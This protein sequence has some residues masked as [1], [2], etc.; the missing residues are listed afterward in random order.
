MIPNT[1]KTSLLV[2]YQLPQFV[3]ENPEY[4]NFQVFL[5][6]Y[7]EWL[8]L[9]NTANSAITEAASTGQGVVFGSSNLLQYGDIDTTIDA[10]I[11]YY[12]NDFLPYFPKESLVSQ[13]RAVKF[14]KQL[15]Q[16][17]GTP[18]SYQFLFRILYNSDFEYYKT[19]DTILRA[20]AGTWYVA[21]SLKLA[22]SDLRFLQIKN[23]RVLLV[24]QFMSTT[25]TTAV[26][27]QFSKN[28]TSI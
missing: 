4:S 5:Q 23:L 22:T 9:A 20:S 12:V 1:Q 27:S 18:A 17:K 6:A 10:F 7:Y 11:D 15:Y 3:R 2:P 13:Q 24:F 19:S 8:E 16:S 26:I 21:K 14:A 25:I 28:I